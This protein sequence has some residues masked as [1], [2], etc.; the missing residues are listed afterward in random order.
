MAKNRK[1]SKTRY[2]IVSLIFIL[3]FFFMIIGSEKNIANI[4]KK[5]ENDS[6]LAST[7]KNA[8]ANLSPI[9]T[10][11][12]KKIKTIRVIR[13][14][15]RDFQ[16]ILD[17][18]YLFT[19]SEYPNVRIE[20]SETFFNLKVCLN[21][22]ENEVREILKQI[23]WI[24]PNAKIV[25]EVHNPKSII[26]QEIENKKWGKKISE[27]LI[28]SINSIF[29]IELANYNDLK[30][31]ILKAKYLEEVEY[32]DYWIIKKE[33]KYY[34]NIGKSKSLLQMYNL[35]KQL[36]KIFHKSSLS[37]T[38]YQVELVL[39]PEKQI[40]PESLKT[41]IIESEKIINQDITP[42][43]I[44]VK[45]IKY[46]KPSENSSPV[47]IYIV[48][49]VFILLLVIPF[50]PAIKEINL[51]RD[52]EPLYINMKYNKDPRYFEKSFR[53]LINNGLETSE[54]FRDKEL[55]EIND[56][57]VVLS[58]KEKISIIS[59][60]KIDTY[61]DSE[62]IL[63]VLDRFE[64]KSDLVFRKEIYAKDKGK[65][66]EKNDLRA[67][68]GDDDLYFSKKTKIVRWVG[69]SGNITFQ[70]ESD[71]GKR[72]ACGKVLEIGKNCKFKS[73]FADPIVTYK[74]TDF[75]LKD[76]FPSIQ[77]RKIPDKLDKITDYHAIVQKNDFIVHKNTVIDRNLIARKNLT[78]KAGVLVNFSIKCY[79]IINL[80]KGS[81][82]R[83]DIF[84]D[85]SIITGENCKIRGCLFSQNEI[86]LG[87]G[88]RVGLKGLVK[89]VIGKKKVS[90]EADVK[91]YGYVLTEGLGKVL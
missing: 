17:Y 60:K 69:T 82:V 73:L 16:Q 50:L 6:S 30:E 11:H 68:L 21:Q 43:I 42:E 38:K 4:V 58:K 27:G 91:I 15:K 53:D 85:N 9:S 45:E 36:N 89:S 63:Y 37:Y 74:A 19:E 10:P 48:T 70:D 47:Y 78:I 44:K 31:A 5:I 80:E 46:V 65:F 87:K 1:I 28:N 24:F 3:S 22:S 81:I 52:A 88:T 67:V 79:G 41:Q 59:S 32:E 34:L 57:E 62:N 35:N 72:V 7:N 54:Q 40:A 25:N 83:G 56:V 84:S 66:G 18:A 23:K 29:Y 75:E 12:L 76:D 61:N 86:Y 26:F 39:Y 77:K 20:E 13:V 90:L 14:Y 33:D 49:S 55:S 8:Q 64:T 2:W 71:L 51:A